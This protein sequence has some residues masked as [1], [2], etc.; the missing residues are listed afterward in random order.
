[1]DYS[2]ALSV[3]LSFDEILFEYFLKNNNKSRQRIIATYLTESV[4]MEPVINISKA[5]E[6]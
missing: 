4:L 1:M 5:K 3:A 2:Y 6:R